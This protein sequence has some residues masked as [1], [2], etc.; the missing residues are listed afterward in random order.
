MSDQLVTRLEQNQGINDIALYLNSLSHE[1]RLIEINQLS[2]KDLKKLYEKGIVGVTIEDLVPKKYEPLKEV[3]FQGRNSLPLNR[4]FQKR[5]CRSSDDLH[6]IG[7]NHQPLMWASGPGY[8]VASGHSE[9]AG[10][11]MIDY[12]QI[13]SEKPGSWP[14][15]KSNETGI[16]YLVYGGMK[17]F[18]RKVSSHVFIG[19]ACKK[20]K[21]LN[22]YFI[23]C[24]N[25]L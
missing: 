13:P 5:M 17:D 21:S 12:T 3:I 1:E 6:L 18:L 2:S 19:E 10:E 25:S 20:G 23:L 9:R 7:Y 24:R 11:V 22:Q 16:G 14:L 8:Y 15:I 4:S